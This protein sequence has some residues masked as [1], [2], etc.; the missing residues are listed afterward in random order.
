MVIV[1][2]LLLIRLLIRH[3]RRCRHHRHVKSAHIKT[4]LTDT[5]IKRAELDGQPVDGRIVGNNNRKRRNLD[6][7]IFKLIEIPILKN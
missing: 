3:A 7:S 5:E 1:V 6:E 2:L 4:R